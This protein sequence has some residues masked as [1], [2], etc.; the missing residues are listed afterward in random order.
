MFHVHTHTI[1]YCRA[2]LLCLNDVNFISE[3]HNINIVFT[4]V[5]W[6]VVVQLQKKNNYKS[7]KKRLTYSYWVYW[8]PPKHM[9]V[10]SLKA[11]FFLLAISGDIFMRGKILKTDSP[12][13]YHFQTSNY[14]EKI[15]ATLFHQEIC[16]YLESWPLKTKF[17]RTKYIASEFVTGVTWKTLELF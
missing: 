14:S 6:W 12:L 8:V 9:T 7:K 2:V 16:L 17:T 5:L 3:I 10:R 11:N 4:L 13:L 15:S 1:F